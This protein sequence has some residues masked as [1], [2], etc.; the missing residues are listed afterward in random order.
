M[1]Q[2]KADGMFPK[3]YPYLIPNSHLPQAFIRGQAPPFAVHL[4]GSPITADLL[5]GSGGG[6]SPFSSYNST[7]LN[8]DNLQD[9]KFDVI[10]LN[11]ISL[12]SS[13]T[14]RRCLRCSNFSRVFKNKP[15]PFL[16][17]RLNHRCL[18]GGLFL[19]YTRTPIA[20]SS[21]STSNSNTNTSETATS[22]TGR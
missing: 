9:T 6:S 20:T 13:P 2:A 1:L 7:L 21:S 19:L 17:Y 14:F 12:S 10:S 8:D 22:A 15:Y 3:T 11:K 16:T 5:V 18:C 4:Y